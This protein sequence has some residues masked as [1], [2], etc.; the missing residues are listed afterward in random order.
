M[1]QEA[2]VRLRRRPGGR[3]Y[4]R[5]CVG[6]LVVALIATSACSSSDGGPVQPVQPGTIELS[7]QTTGFMKDASYELLVDGVSE[8][9]VSA[10]DEVTL[11]ELDPGTY[12]ISLGDVAPNCTT[13]DVSVDVTED[14]TASASLEVVCA[15]EAASEYTIRFNRARPNLNDGTI[16]EC[17]FS[18]C[19]TEEGW[20]MYVTL[21]SGNPV[22]RVNGTTLVEIAHVSGVTLETMTEADYASAVFG[23]DPI[24]DPFDENRVILIRTDTGDIYALGNPVEN[25]LAQT[26]T[27]DAALVEMAS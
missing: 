10:S 24:D 13:E 6:G 9:A 21:T 26:L 20:D 1:M 3:A 14:E 17:P 7:V 16:T 2:I 25:S 15:F 12:L 23:A 5:P 8:G 27:F 19:P 22:V 11:S 4:R 18:L